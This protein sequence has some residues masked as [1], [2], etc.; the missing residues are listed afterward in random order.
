MKHT[1]NR[2][3]SMILALTMLLGT[4]ALPV[5]A[6]ETEENAS[7]QITTEESNQT[8]GQEASEETA[9]QEDPDGLS[10]Q[11][12]E[13]EEEEPEE[14]QPKEVKP[15]T[16]DDGHWI[17]YPDLLDSYTFPENWSR[18]ALEFCVGNKIIQGREDGLAPDA[19][20]TRAETAAILVRLLGAQANP[21][22]LYG[23][24]DVDENAWY[25]D[26]L[27]AAV[28]VGLV[29]GTSATTVNPNGK[30]TRE[31]ACVLLSRAF[32]ILPTDNKAHEAFA[33]AAAVANYAKTAVGAL[34]QDGVLKGYGDNTVRPKNNITRA[35]FAKL[36]YECVTHVVDDPK[37]LPDSG[38]VI[39]RG[40]KNLPKVYCLDGDLIVGCGF[41]DYYILEW[42][43]ITGRIVLRTDPAAEIS[44]VG[45]EMAELSVV[46]PIRVTSSINIPAVFVEAA[47]AELNVPATDLYAFTDCTLENTYSNIYLMKG[48]ICVT[49]DGRADYACLYEDYTTLEGDGFCQMV[50]IYG[51][52]CPVTVSSAEWNDHNYWN[53]YNSALSTVSTVSSWYN[54]QRQEPYRLG[55]LEGFVNQMGYASDTEYLIWVSTTTTSV[56]V[57]KGS[58]G[59]WKLEKSMD[60]ALGASYSPTVRG[61]FKT[62]MIDNEWDFG[63]Y[64]CRWVTYFYGGYAFHSRKWSPDY[65]YLVDPSINCLVSAGCVRMYDEDCYYIYSTIPLGTTVVVY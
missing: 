28:H 9:Q 30:L 62:F 59:N 33:D 18:A 36:V 11:A 44:L 63:A 16:T 39:Y 32:G 31:D 22:A 35:E 49:L 24:E 3:I 57:F 5:W 21:V 10:E 19:S 29:K 4:F 48:G 7:G 27:S 13:S 8:D 54:Y 26:E 25:Y 55:T 56:N 42:M 38:K 14:T 1:M 41:D 40:T 65:S 15:I 34:A 20:I 2:I 60:C 53:W 23:Y 51:R 43:G 58:Q 46:S 12:E 6:A 52:E 17:P 61:T 50:E 64:K 37:Q 45:C 47:G